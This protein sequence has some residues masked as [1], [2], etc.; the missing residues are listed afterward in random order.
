[1]TKKPPLVHRQFLHQRPADAH[2]HGADHLAARRLGVEDAPGGA[3]RQ[4]AA[5]ARLARRGIDGDLD[6]VPAKVDCW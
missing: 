5:D 6:E 3:D 1:L 4:H 2:G